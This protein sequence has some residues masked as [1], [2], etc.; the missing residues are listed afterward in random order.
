MS[1][2]TAP[3]PV[4]ARADNSGAVPA[5]YRRTEV[6]LIPEDW[7]VRSLEEIADPKQPICY[8]IVQ[9]GPFVSG[10]IPV[11]AIKNL[12]TDYRT[13]VHQCSPGIE[14]PY[15]RSRVR[16]GDVLISVKGTA[17]RVGIVPSHFAGNISRDLARIRLSDENVPEFWLQM[18]QSE[19]AQR[20][21]SLATVGTTRLEL[22]IGTLKQVRMPRPP[23]DEQRA[24]AATLSDVDGLI[25]ALDKLIA[26]KRAIKQGA[27]QQSLTG[28]TRLRGF[29]GTWQ[30][31]NL[32]KLVELS[33]GAQLNRSRLLADGYPVWN[34][35]VTPSGFTDDWNMR[36]NT[37]TVSEGGN[38][39]GFVGFLTEKFWC[40][41]HCY[42]V[43][44]RD[45]T[46]DLS[47]L[48]QALKFREKAIMALR[49]GSG[50]PNIQKERLLGFTIEY[51]AADEQ[52]AIATVLSDMDVE[53]AALERRR[54]KTKTIKQGMM[55]VLLTGQV[56]LIHQETA[57]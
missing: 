14:T 57:V 51:P 47:F 7:E 40:G 55:Q 39:C 20:E 38:S 3:N 16:S 56:R 26:K 13:N 6:G 19:T 45:A 4:R 41:G 25:A 30:S 21:L 37:I 53:I 28:R 35:G 32:A 5:G 54:N 15:A 44:N 43:E 48:Y 10:G 24:I 23:S 27:M 46:L 33:K 52:R 42:G 8:G 29:S 18:L 49:V 9:V 12:N 17:G 36:G 50:L 34:G 22:S 2:N 31:A 1:T 11:L